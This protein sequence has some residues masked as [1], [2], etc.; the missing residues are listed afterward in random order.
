MQH[1]LVKKPYED[2]PALFEWLSE[3]TDSNL[4]GRWSLTT[5]F[6]FHC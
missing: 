3:F 6:F 1:V 5:Y 4:A 2:V